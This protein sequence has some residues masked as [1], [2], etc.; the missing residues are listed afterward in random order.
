MVSCIKR[1]QS[2]SKAASLLWWANVSI[3]PRK[4]AFQGH[5]SAQSASSSCTTAAYRHC[6]WQWLPTCCL[7]AAS[8]SSARLDNTMAILSALTLFWSSLGLRPGSLLELLAEHS[9]LQATCRAPVGARSLVQLCHPT[10]CLRRGLQQGGRP[11][12][13]GSCSDWAPLLPVGPVI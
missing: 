11:W 2:K 9:S 6:H 8:V 12:A 10:C 1:V 3:N 4:V 7:R 5:W 13:G